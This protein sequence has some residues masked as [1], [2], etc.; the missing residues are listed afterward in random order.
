MPEDAGLLCERF[1]ERRA[2]EGGEDFV[3]G[4]ARVERERDVGEGGVAHGLGDRER[5]VLGAV[6]EDVERSRSHD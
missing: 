6:F 3:A 2:A 4:I 1:G 5:L